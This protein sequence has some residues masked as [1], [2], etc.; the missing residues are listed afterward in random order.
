MPKEDVRWS[1]IANSRL[2][3]S[4]GVRARL[5]L[6]AALDLDGGLMAT[7]LVVEDDAFIRQAAEWTMEDIGHTTLSASDLAGA[8]EHLASGQPIDALFVDIR[9]S[10]LVDGG[11]AV[12]NQAIRLQPQLRVLYTSGTTLDSGMIDRFVP[13]GHFLEKPYSPMQLEASVGKLLQ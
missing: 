5:F 7:I 1:F 6:H 8:L 11:Y 13:G 3:I 10:A 4:R 2:P 12:A 9:L